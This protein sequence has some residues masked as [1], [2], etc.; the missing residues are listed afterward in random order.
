MTIRITLITLLISFLSIEAYAQNQ[1]IGFIDSDYIL[2]KIP[3]YEGVDQRL[4]QIKQNW[5]EEIT[6]MRQ[7]LESMEQ[8]FEAKEILFTPEVRAER[9]QEI[10]NKR[11]D[12][13][14]FIDSRFGPDG[15]YFRQQ[16]EL[17]EPI[18]RQVV[19]AVSKVAERD[20]YDFVFDR[21]GDYVFFY[22]RRQWNISI[23]VLL[24]MGIQVDEETTR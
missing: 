4:S 23:D 18:Q 10:N 14:R 5:E 1:R 20:G 6:E 22:A 24:E 16:R 19:E 21:T 13:E 2:S 7:E 3:E 17:L 11:R 9:E 8:D 15:D 12:I